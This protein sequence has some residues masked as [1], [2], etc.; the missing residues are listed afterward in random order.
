MRHRGPLRLAAS[1]FVLACSLAGAADAKLYAFG[2]SLSDTGNINTIT[3]GIEPGSDYWRGRFSNGP[4]WV[5]RLGYRLGKAPGLFYR[6]PA[7][8]SQTDG[9]SFAHGGAAAVERWYLPDFLEAQGQASYYWNQ[10]R[11]GRVT[12]RSYDIATLWIGGNDYLL[13]DERSAPTVVNGVMRSLRTLDATGIGH[14][15]VFNLPYLGEIPGEIRGPDRAALNRVSGQHNSL[16]HAELQRFRPTARARIVTVDANRIFSL[17]RQGVGGFTVT[18]PGDR[19]SRTGSC[20]G[21]GLLLAACPAHYFFYDGVHPT[22]SGHQFIAG[23]VLDRLAGR[24]AALTR[25]ALAV[26]ATTGFSGLQLAAVRARLDAAASSSE[27]SASGLTAFGFGADA[28]TP[29]AALASDDQEGFGVEWRSD[30]VMLGFSASTG[31]SADGDR[32]RDGMSADSQAQGFAAYAG[33]SFDGALLDATV[34]HARALQSYTRLTAIDT[35]GLA[36]GEAWVAQTVTTMGLSRRFEWGAFSVTPEL[37]GLH[38]RSEADAFREQ[39]TMGLS[40]N[41]YEAFQADGTLGQTGL[42]AAYGGDGWG[43]SLSVRM[44]AR[45]DGQA[46]LRLLAPQAFANAPLDDASV[47]ADLGASAWGEVWIASGDAW[48]LRAEGGVFEAGGQREEAGLITAKFA[49]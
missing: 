37:R 5:E 49:F 14:I 9:Y 17:V 45:L 2:D 10:A 1:A 23:V 20:K 32:D 22:A 30:S 29:G 11:K 35:L 3:F 13:Y 7:F 27:G 40:D 38:A 19:G 21:D 4:V 43:A 48:S 25:D 47:A 26:A 46:P 12:A 6:D 36:S 41:D 39:G 33:L 18:K 8:A 15:V 31:A 28:G 34:S 16:L 24:A 42:T 44:I